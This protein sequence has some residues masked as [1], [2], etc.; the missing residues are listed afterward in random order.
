M[1]DAFHAACKESQLTSEVH[2]FWGHTLYHPHNALAALKPPA[3]DSNSQLMSA[4]DDLDDVRFNDIQAL[5]ADVPH[6]MTNFRKVSCSALL[7]GVMS[8]NDLSD[9]QIIPVQRHH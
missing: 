2:H 7:M 1:A 8:S 9:G 3:R 5:F 6:V 4:P